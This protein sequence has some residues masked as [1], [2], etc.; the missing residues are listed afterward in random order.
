MIIAI[1]GQTIE[2]KSWW[3]VSHRM[4]SAG[5][6][7][8]TLGNILVDK[9]KFVP[10]AF[11][12]PLKRICTDVYAFTDAQMWGASENRNAIDIRYGK[13]PREALQKLG[14]EWGRGFYSNTWI[15]YALRLAKQIESGTS[16]YSPKLGIMNQKYIGPRNILITDVRYINEFYAIKEAGGKVIRCKRNVEKLGLVPAHK[17]ETDILKI[18]DSEFDFIIENNGTIKDLEEKARGLAEQ[19]C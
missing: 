11:A 17:S 7:K 5:S 16:D 6:G 15:D 10:I 18:K 9:Y 3:R 13:A 19:I 12:D 14:D 1:S 2:R 4:G 8:D